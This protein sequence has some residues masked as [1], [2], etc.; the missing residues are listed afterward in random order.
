MKLVGGRR[1][2]HSGER[3]AVVL[4]ENHEQVILAELVVGLVVNRLPRRFQMT[5]LGGLLREYSRAA[6]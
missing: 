4:K 3:S 5:R 6:A 1:L 2:P